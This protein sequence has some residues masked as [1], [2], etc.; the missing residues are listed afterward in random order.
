M[1]VALGSIEVSELERKAINNRYGKRGLATRKDVVAEV[2]QVFDS[3]M[4]DLIED[5]TGRKEHD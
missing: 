3:H 5:L 4:D 1:K 2:H